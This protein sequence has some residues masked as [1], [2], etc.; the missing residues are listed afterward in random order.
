VTIAVLQPDPVERIGPTPIWDVAS[1]A[2]D[3]V[4][5]EAGRRAI[6]MVPDGEATGARLA[7][8]DV[9]SDTGMH[10]LHITV[11]QANPEVH[12]RRWVSAD[13]PTSRSAR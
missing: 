1:S 8:S 10:P 7:V 6:V 3:V 12:A 2:V 11:R 9:A 13:S 5:R 4:S